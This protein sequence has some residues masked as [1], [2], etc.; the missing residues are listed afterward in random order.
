MKKSVF[1]LVLVM[2]LSIIFTA[3]GFA[4]NNTEFKNI[5][6]IS[7]VK[8]FNKAINNV[9]D[10]TLFLG[11]VK[12]NKTTT[13]DLKGK[14]IKLNNL[15]NI[16]FQ[17]ITFKNAKYIKFENSSN[18][19]FV[20]VTFEKFS[21]NGLYLVDSSNINITE[22]NFDNIGSTNINPT[23]QGNGIYASNT[24]GLTVTNSEFSRTYGHG[25]VFLFASEEF[26]ISNN[27][28]HD[29]FYRAV[30][31]YEGILS[32]T[33]KNNKIYDIGSINTS[34]SGVGANGIYGKGADLS[35][36]SILNNN[37][38]NVLENGI[39]GPFGLVEGNYING[40]GMD[41]ANHPTP[42]AEGIY[43]NGLVYRNN[44]VKNT[45]NAGIKVYS[46]GLIENTTIENNEVSQDLFDSE[47]FGIALISEGGYSNILIKNN[48]INNYR[49]DV[50]IY[51]YENINDDSIEIALNN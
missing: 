40:T 10:S 44:V 2:S 17:D 28:F 20:N 23:Y 42:S 37:I 18:L 1:M 33:V 7:N 35:G 19:E 41:L 34:N 39:E 15:N 21:H 3:I 4:S 11:K 49:D 24:L 32:G 25:G 45:K 29:T 26:E 43:A 14:S 8:S 30:M 9:S 38:T 16:K 12:G 22:S 31:M 27:E 51:N 5:E 48:I 36:V 46:S 13:I 6:N 50:F 47:H